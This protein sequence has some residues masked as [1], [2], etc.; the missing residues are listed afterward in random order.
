[1]SSLSIFRNSHSAEPGGAP[2][3]RAVLYS[4]KLYQIHRISRR[5]CRP[6]LVRLCF[7]LFP[8]L[9]SSSFLSHNDSPK[10]ITDLLNQING[11]FFPGGGSNIS[12]TPLYDA[13][14]TIF[15]YAQSVLF[16]FLSS[17]PFDPH[18]PDLSFRRFK[19]AIISPCSV[20]ARVS[21]SF[22]SSRRRTIRF[23][24]RST[25]RTSLCAPRPS[26]FSLHIL[27]HVF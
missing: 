19:K 26:A 13:A 9:L 6:N 7:L 5:S 25:P 24:S 20:T 18:F 21:K 8:P 22:R 14:L 17:I 27:I 3:V 16:S 12:H 4:C 1:M 23:S 2:K 10:A 15:N 11:A